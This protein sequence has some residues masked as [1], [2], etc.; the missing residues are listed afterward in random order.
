MIVGGVSREVVPAAREDDAETASI[1]RGERVVSDL[2]K[3]RIWD[4]PAIRSGL[5]WFPGAV[6]VPRRPARFYTHKFRE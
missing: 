1:S 3:L 6:C 4:D 2:T 5:A